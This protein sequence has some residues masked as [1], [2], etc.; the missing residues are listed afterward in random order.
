MSS[1]YV[2]DGE[3][4]LHD[5]QNLA[6]SRGLA[7]DNVGVSNLRYPIVVLDRQMEKQHTVATLSLSVGLPHHFKGTHMSRFIEIMNQ[8]RGE[9]TVRTLPAILAE[10]RTRLDAESARIEVRFPYF[11]EKAAPSSGAKALMDY[12]CAFNAEVNGSKS[13][14]VVSVSVPVTSLCPCSKAIS[15][16]GAHNQRG[17]I[18]IQVRSL[19]GS[20]IVWI[21]ELVAIAEAAASAPVYPL[22]KRADERHVTMQAYDNPVFVEDMVRE[23]AGALLED[24]RVAWFSVEAVN[25]ESIHNHSAFARIERDLTQQIDS[26]SI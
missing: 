3:S 20:D 15:D 18:A 21:E 14:F 23:V 1:Q 11:I 26:R 17:T 24:P 19:D 25:E 2:T 12:E 4:V 7:I 9:V 13:D 10:I 22:L 16:Y 6:D 8:H 5:I